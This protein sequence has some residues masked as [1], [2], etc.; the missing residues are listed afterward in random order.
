M[1]KYLPLT[2]YPPLATPLSISFPSQSLWCL[3][4]IGPNTEPIVYLHAGKLTTPQ[5]TVP[6]S[7]MTLVAGFSI[8]QVTHARSYI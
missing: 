7:F 8:T 5:T 4:V 6:F 3:K 2:L 1:N